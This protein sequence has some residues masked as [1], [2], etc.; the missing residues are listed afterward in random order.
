MSR[1]VRAFWEWSWTLAHCVPQA[2]YYYKKEQLS[3]TI[4]NIGTKPIFF[5]NDQHVED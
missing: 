2:Y 5:F 1:E 3:K 4:S